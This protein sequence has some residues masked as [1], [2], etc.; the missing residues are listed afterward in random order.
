MI[1]A[2]IDNGVVVNTQIVVEGNVFDPAFTWVDISEEE[3]MPG[4]GWAYD[5]DVFTPPAEG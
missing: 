4:I 3:P 5:G 1:Y 2:K